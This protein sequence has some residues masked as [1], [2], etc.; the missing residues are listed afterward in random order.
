MLDFFSALAQ[1]TTLEDVWE[2]HCRA[3]EAL[4]FDRLIYGYTQFAQLDSLGN[5]QDALFLSNHPA[6]YFDRFIGERMF[7]HAPLMRWARENVGACS[8]GALWD[9]PAAIPTAVLIQST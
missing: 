7:L 8:W 6:A 1:A 4:G 3:M 9:A 5:P 2:T